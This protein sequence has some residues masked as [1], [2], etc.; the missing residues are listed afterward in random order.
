LFKAIIRKYKKLIFMNSIIF[1][2]TKD[3]SDISELRK[4]EL[5]ISRSYARELGKTALEAINSG[6]YENSSGDEVLWGEQIH[7]CRESKK[8]ISPDVKLKRKENSPFEKTFIQVCN[9][10][11]LQASLRLVEKGMRPLALNFA[12]GIKPGGGFLGGARAQEEVLCRSSALYETLKGDPMYDFHRKRSR[13]DSSNW[14]IYSPDVPVFRNDAG[15]ALEKPWLLSFLTSA[16]PYAPAIGQPESGDLLK[17]RIHRV[18]EIAS[19]FDYDAL[20]LGAWG[21]GAFSNDPQRTA[22]D[23]RNIL[24]Q[25]FLGHFSE[26]IFAVTDWSE[27]RRF[28]GPFRD[29]F[30]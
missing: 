16:A 25:E 15:N 17:S 6:I 11:T 22:M 19:A 30:C 21:C 3:S 13:P 1:L 27:E 2:P 29:T 24:E 23:F 9:E 14:M 4:K 8:S 5:N 12:N 7:H 18:Y 28:L 20:V 26:I 10:T